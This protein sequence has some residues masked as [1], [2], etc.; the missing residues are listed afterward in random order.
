[1]LSID[2][3][4]P[5]GGED[6]GTDARANGGDGASSTLADGGLAAEPSHDA[7]ALPPV[8][9]LARVDVAIQPPWRGA[10]RPLAGSGL[11]ALVV[12]AVYAVSFDGF[13]ETPTYQTALFAVRGAT[14]LGPT[15]GLVLFLAGLVAFLAVFALIATLT[16]YLG[17]LTR[18]S[19]ALAPTLVP[20]AAAYE[21]AHTY[22]YVAAN[23]G[24]LPALFDAGAVDPLWWL[25]VPAFWTSQVVLIVAGHL[26]AV[27]AAHL[28][29]SRRLDRSGTFLAHLPLVGLMVGYTMLS[30][31]IVSQ[32]VVA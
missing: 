16:G 27:L 13:V 7:L 24:R 15:A 1:V 17:G 11:V 28:V 14:G 4:G 6:L 29:L 20:I 26:V 21:V 31:W 18:P 22:P 25:G 5:G 8:R 10:A 23:L 3:E 12:T 2:V 32:P 9:R 30:L 19:L